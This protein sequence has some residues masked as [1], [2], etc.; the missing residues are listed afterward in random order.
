MIPAPVNANTINE[1]ALL[2]CR[3]AVAKTPDNTPLREVEVDV[4]M[5]CLNAF[6]DRSLIDSSKRY[7]PNMKIPKPASECQIYINFM[8]NNIATKN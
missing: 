5:K 7:I 2:L 8:T 4:L 3:I 6:P 1:T